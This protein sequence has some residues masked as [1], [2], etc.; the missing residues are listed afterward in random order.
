MF[1][2]LT[3]RSP[4]YQI[5]FFRDGKQSSRSTNTKNRKEAELILK[6]FGKELKE[7]PLKPKEEKSVSLEKFSR[8]YLEIMKLSCSESYY[9]RSVRPALLNLLKEVGNK[10][11]SNLTPLLLEKFLLNLYQRSKYN[12]ALYLRVLKASFNKAIAWGY[13]ENNPCSRIRLP[14][15]QQRPIIFITIEQLNLILASTHRE[16][17]KNIFLFAFL[18]GMRASEILNLTWRCINLEKQVINVGSDNFRTKSSKIRSVPISEPALHLLRKYLPKH[19]SIKDGYVFRKGIECKYS[20]DFISKQFKKSVRRAELP[21]EIHFHTLR[22]SFGSFL[23]QKGV[24]ISTISKLLGHSSIVVT[25][26]HYASLA[27][28][29]LQSAVE[30]FSE[31]I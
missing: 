22:A 8:E 25:E 9:K 19:L 21:E 23:L 15:I 14:K 26:K 27:I 17:Y 11:L 24:P 10:K 5:V 16:I 7:S 20:V 30:K 4:Y 1:L 12:A 18:T 31:V 3:K 29:N 13:L 2:T 6:M 28:S